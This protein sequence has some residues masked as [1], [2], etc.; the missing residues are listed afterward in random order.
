MV[1]QLPLEADLVG[2][3]PGAECDAEV[4]AGVWAPTEYWAICAG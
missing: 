4:G 2:A 1:E 3:G